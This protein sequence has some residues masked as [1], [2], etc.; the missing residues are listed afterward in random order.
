MNININK[1][2]IYMDDALMALFKFGEQDKLLMKCEYCNIFSVKKRIL[3]KAG[4]N[5][6][7]NTYSFHKLIIEDIEKFITYLEMNKF[8]QE[9]IINNMFKLLELKNILCKYG[10]ISFDDFT[11][12]DNELSKKL[13]N[14]MIQYYRH[15]ILIFTGE[16]ISSWHNNQY[17]NNQYPNNHEYCY[18]DLDKYKYKYKNEKAH[19]VLCGYFIYGITKL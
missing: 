10:Q 13:D 9:S 7:F 14:K 3:Y 8:Y 5:K 2:N 16:D 6:I 4:S 19:L 1:Y 12:Q 11:E 17:P 18:N 15:I